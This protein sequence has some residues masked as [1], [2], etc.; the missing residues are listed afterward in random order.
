MR[1]N[2]QPR[3]CRE[4]TTKWLA[5]HDP[6]GNWDIGLRKETRKTP[7]GRGHNYDFEGRNQTTYATTK[8]IWATIIIRYMCVHD[9]WFSTS[10]SAAGFFRIN[11]NV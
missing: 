10:A 8:P 9:G 6:F 11:L 5:R 7:P 4:N 3:C 1:E 2:L